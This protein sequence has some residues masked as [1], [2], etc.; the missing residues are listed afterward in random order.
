MDNP[1]VKYN[2]N[3]ERQNPAPIVTLNKQ[4]I[5]TTQIRQAIDM[6]PRVN[7]AKLPTPLEDAAGLRQFLRQQGNSVPRLLVKREDATGFAF[8]GNKARHFEHII[9]KAQNDGC[10]TV[11]SINDYHSNRARFAAAAAAKCGLKC[12][13]I[14]TD[15]VDEPLTGNLLLAK[16]AGAEIHRTP[17]EY[18]EQIALKAAEKCRSEGGVPYIVNHDTFIDWV[19]AA[20]FIR[21]GIE[22]EEQLWRQGV[23]GRIVLWGVVGQSLSGL[24]LYAKLRY[25]P[26]DAVGVV[27]S[28]ISERWGYEKDDSASGYSHSMFRAANAAADALGLP[29]HLSPDDIE[30]LIGYQG[31]DYSIP[32][33]KMLEAM[34]L[35]ARTD[36]FI[37]DPNYTGRSMAALLGEI[38]KGRF[39]PDDTV[40]FIHSGG[41]PQIFAFSDEI[42]A[43][44]DGESRIFGEIFKEKAQ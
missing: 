5:P 24:K 23:R 2:L 41:T 13:L 40:V 15:R 25:L 44:R 9:A 39:N 14:S 26:W 43:W 1:K 4:P 17:F 38:E 16:L 32:Y 42:W 36:G 30:T 33:P 37:L 8:G 3:I 11:I 28:P 18:A 7:L 34:H 22:L 20:A 31:E 27:Y 19:G 21:A 12:V 6:L 35:A 29:A 10:T